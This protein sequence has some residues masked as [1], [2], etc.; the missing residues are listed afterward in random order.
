MHWTEPRNFKEWF[1]R[2]ISARSLVVGLLFLAIMTSELRFDWVEQILGSFLVS[3]NPMR[4]ESGAIWEVGKHTQAAHQTIEKIVTDRQAFYR[5]TGDASS[6]KQ[7]AETIQADE[8]VLVPPDLF[9]KLYLRLPPE[10]ATEII[11][12]MDFLELINHSE[13]ARTYFEKDGTGLNIYM[14]DKDNRVL[15]RLSISADL[16]YLMVHSDVIFNKKLDDFTIFENRIYT[17]DLFFEVL[18]GLDDDV[19]NGIIRRPAHILRLPGRIVRV[20][21]SD[22]AI[23]GFIQIGFEVETGAQR[24]LVLVRGHEWA[25]WRL[26]SLLEGKKTIQ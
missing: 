1:N 11:E 13:W 8:W 5:E 17:G 25:V 7:I 20:G 3:T 9:R 24:R 19:K 12:P 4:P 14:L 2:L 23:S 26:H 6:F 15:K 22:E 16:L 21:I 10:V 18:N